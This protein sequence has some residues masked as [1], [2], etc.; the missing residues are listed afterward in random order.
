MS[1]ASA[2]G[3]VICAV[4]VS[5]A[6]GGWIGGWYLPEHH[7]TNETRNAVSLSM[8]V[9]GTVSALVLGLLISQANSAFLAGSNEVTE[10]A[11][12]IARL[13]RLLRRDEPET[14]TARATLRRYAEM[15]FADLFPDPPGAP[16]LNNPATDDMLDHVIDQLQELS[17]ST[18][19]QQ[20]MITRA[21][22]LASDISGTQWLLAEQSVQALPTPF[23]VLITFWLTLL[24]ISFGLFAPRNLTVGVSFVL[25]A[26]AVSG[27]IEMILELEQPF[28]GMIRISPISMRTMLQTLGG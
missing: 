16:R 3:G 8:A 20:W 21:L 11:T 18:P 17:H 26:L 25:C 10:L 19:Q 24:F 7:T 23:L 4:I 27:A 15:K 5:G 2:I 6:M 28:T 12:D 14:A 9:V 13:D 1:S 22:Q